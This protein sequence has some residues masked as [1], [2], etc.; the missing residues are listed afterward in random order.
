MAKGKRKLKKL[1]SPRPKPNLIKK[2]NPD[3]LLKGISRGSVHE[4]DDK[5]AF[6]FRHLD[7]KQGNLIRDWEGKQLLGNA[8]STLKSYSSMTLKEAERANFTIYGG[9]PPQGKTDFQH[10]IHVPPD[11]KWASMHVQGAVCLAGH[12]VGNI[13]YVVFLDSDHR[14]WISEKKHT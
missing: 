1:K 13:F 14:F 8:F 10:P 4:K 2:Q 5:L 7:E 12:V 11:A 9:F 6:N 3:N